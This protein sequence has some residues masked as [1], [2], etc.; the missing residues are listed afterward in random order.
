MWIS[1]GQVHTNS[2]W[3]VQNVVGE[4]WV[5]WERTVLFV[6]SGVFFD[7]MANYAQVVEGAV[8][9]GVRF[10]IRDRK[11]LREDGK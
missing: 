8:R 3:E 4:D 1:F 10:F 5:T 7:V 2:S 9:I 6:Q 11:N